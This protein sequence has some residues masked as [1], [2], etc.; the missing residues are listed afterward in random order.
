MSELPIPVSNLNG[1]DLCSVSD[2]ME[3][4]SMSRSAFYGRLKALDITPKKIGRGAYVTPK[5]VSDVLSLH[6]FL[7]EGGKLEVFLERLRTGSLVAVQTEQVAIAKVEADEVIEEEAVQYDFSGLEIL[8][9]ASDHGWRLSSGELGQLLNV[10]QSTISSYAPNFQAKGFSFT[11]TDARWRGA[12]EW[13][14]EQK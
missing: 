2:L 8:Q 6:K 14:I 4:L 9:K 10:S 7:H 13:K 3:F 12:Y 11:R 1:E 5:Q